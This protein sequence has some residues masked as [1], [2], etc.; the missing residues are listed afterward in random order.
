MV[1]LNDIIDMYSQMN[2][3]YLEM[4][5]KE[6]YKYECVVINKELVFNFDIII[7][8]SIIDIDFKSFIPTNNN[9]ETQIMCHLLS[10]DIFYDI[11]DFIETICINAK[12]IKNYCIS[13]FDKLNYS[14]DIFTT[15]G[16]E[17]CKYKIEEKLLDNDVSE[18]F[19]P[20]EI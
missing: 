8:K 16:S 11:A 12:N 4:Y 13:C 14:S 18:F 19:T 15:C 10:N 5:Q 6:E 1:L 7:N 9:T 2:N 3:V 20:L 17:K